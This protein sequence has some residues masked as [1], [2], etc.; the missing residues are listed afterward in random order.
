MIRCYVIFLHSFI[1]SHANKNRIVL[2]RKFYQVLHQR[3]RSQR[4]NDNGLKTNCTTLIMRVQ[5]QSHGH[6]HKHRQWK[7][8]NWNR[9]NSPKRKKSKSTYYILAES[10]SFRVVFTRST[11]KKGENLYLT[12]KLYDLKSD[13][14][15]LNKNKSVKIP[16]LV[17]KKRRDEIDFLINA[18]QR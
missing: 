4:T 9:S 10:H 3:I 15:I 2:F 7:R 18:H 16:I 6:G 17:E 5:C 13:M 12:S 1:F 8:G 11:H 14:C